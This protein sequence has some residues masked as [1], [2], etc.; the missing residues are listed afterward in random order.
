MQERQENQWGVVFKNNEEYQ[1][2]CKDCFGQELGQSTIIINDKLEV[3]AKRSELLDAA[4]I[5]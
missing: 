5:L 4:L 1:I 3:D 2:L